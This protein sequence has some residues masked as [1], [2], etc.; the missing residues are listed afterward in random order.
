MK[1][2]TEEDL[3]DLNGGHPKDWPCALGNMAVIAGLFAGQWFFSVGLAYST[4]TYGCY[5]P[6]Y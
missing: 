6:I 2:L 3:E 5:E 1:K 4:W